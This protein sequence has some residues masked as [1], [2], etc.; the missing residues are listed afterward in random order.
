VKGTKGRSCDQWDI[1]QLVFGPRG[2][3][4]Y[5]QEIWNKRTGEI[6]R[7]V[8]AYWRENFDLKYIL[9]RDWAK[10]GPKLLGKLHL[11]VG[12]SDTYYLNDAVYSLEDFLL[13]PQTSPP[14]EAIFDYVSIPT[15]NP[16]RA[17]YTRLMPV[18]VV[19]RQGSHDGRGYEHC[20]S[21][22]HGMPNSLGRLTINA[23]VLPQM[24][25][26]M[27]RTAPAGADLRWHQY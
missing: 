5:V 18:C 16:E 21:G 27:A 2:P 22:I 1:W 8:A 6:N 26:R 20:Y 13:D 7:A 25:E 23:R 15:T 17:D 11:Y 14:S 3:D 19:S 9:Q 4:G 24:A 10:L 12:M